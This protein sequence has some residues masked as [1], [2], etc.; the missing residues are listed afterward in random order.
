M[1]TPLTREQMLYF[2]YR[3]IDLDVWNGTS[4]T[5]EPDI[6]VGQLR[7]SKPGGA[8]K[9]INRLLGRIEA[10]STPK[11]VDLQT[12]VPELGHLSTPTEPIVTDGHALTTPCGF[13]EACQVIR[14]SAFVSTDLPVI[15][16][17]EVHTGSDQQELMVKIMKEE[18]RDVLI[19]KPLE[20]CDPQFRLP[21]LE[22]LRGRILVRLGAIISPPALHSARFGLPGEPGYRPRRSPIIQSLADLAVYLRREE[23]EGFTDMQSKSP[24]HLFSIQETKAQELISTSPTN[25]F[26]HNLEYFFRVYPG[27]ARQGTFNLDPVRFWRY[28][29]QMAG[30][31]RNHVDEGMMLNEAM[32]ADELGWVLKP[33]GYRSSKKDTSNDLVA[34]PRK[35]VDLS[36]FAFKDQEFMTNTG[37]EIKN[38]ASF[39]MVSLHINDEEKPRVPRQQLNTTE[40]ESGA[41]GY[42]L[43]FL[44]TRAEAT[45]IPKLCILR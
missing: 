15:V 29:V 26:R 20:G 1:N 36:I 27:S 7:E 5:E 11:P 13:R 21:T 37:R 41:L 3:S 8:T 17:L 30:I 16:N 33:D 19:D 34:G 24:I 38:L 42:S 32:F 43:N 14:E 6:H 12:T 31:D 28:G 45:I 35:S 40:N 23:F 39:M 4:K 25:L 10:T 44:V 9:T 22:D 18:W 2:G